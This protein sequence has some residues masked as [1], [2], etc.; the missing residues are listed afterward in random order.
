M[1]ATVATAHD[2]LGYTDSLLAQMAALVRGHESAADGEFSV[3]LGPHVRHIIEHFEALVV[4]LRSDPQQPERCVVDYDARL[5]DL[6]VQT[7]PAVA[8][9]RI[10]ALRG[11]VEL[12]A[13]LP[14]QAFE[15][16]V[17][18]QVLAGNAGELSI[19]TQSTVLRELAFLAS[20]CVH[21]FA[22]IKLR[23]QQGGKDLGADFGKAPATVSHESK[24]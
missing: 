19:T 2:M 17:S 10:A 6:A 20:H 22:V 11:S 24:H 1:S 3:F 16:V 13:E 8:L 9:Q 7:Q 4:Q 14:V 18:V 15:R 23:A 12:W 5:R 21:H